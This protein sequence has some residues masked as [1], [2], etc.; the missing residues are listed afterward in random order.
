MGVWR[1]V[2]GGMSVFVR[3]GLGGVVGGGIV[4]GSDGGCGGVGVCCG[5]PRL[6]NRVMVM[7]VLG[8]K[9]WG[10]SIYDEGAADTL[11]KMEML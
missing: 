9:V 5:I 3:R 1:G 10:Y 7:E 8:V 6:D 4:G 2:K 11:G